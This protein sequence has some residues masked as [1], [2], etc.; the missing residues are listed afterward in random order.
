VKL[1]DIFLGY[2]DDMQEG[3]NDIYLYGSQSQFC[4][5]DILSINNFDKWE[6][7]S[8]LIVY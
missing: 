1:G 4:I 3:F 2:E 7:D 8:E 6:I 5:C